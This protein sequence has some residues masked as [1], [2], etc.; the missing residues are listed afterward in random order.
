MHNYDLCLRS[1]I[2]HLLHTKNINYFA[3]GFGHPNGKI[4]YSCT[5]AVIDTLSAAMS[6]M[7]DEL[8]TEEK[9]D[10]AISLRILPIEPAINL[11][12]NCLAN[13]TQVEFQSACYRL[14]KSTNYYEA[15]AE[16]Q[17][18]FIDEKGLSIGI[19]SRY[20]F[21]TKQ[22]ISGENLRKKILEITNNIEENRYG[23]AAVNIKSEPDAT[24]E[25][26]GVG[27][28]EIE[29][30]TCGNDS[31]RVGPTLEECEN[32]YNT[33]WVRDRK[34]FN[35]DKEKQ[36][37][38]QITVPKTGDYEVVAYGSGNNHKNGSGVF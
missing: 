15:L 7:I 30:T 23:A 34:L 38:Q 10:L 18:Y 27:W 4:D 31:G 24:E 5:T 32:A 35:M 2:D 14:I 8:S 33:E 19:V 9:V 6:S 20:L 13:I 36:G 25:P 37:I 17:L 11:A 3:S 12:N 28:D 22:G 16:K 26:I 21:R 1:I 29:L